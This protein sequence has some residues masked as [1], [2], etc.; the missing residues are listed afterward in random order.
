MNADC[1]PH[2]DALHHS[3]TEGTDLSPESLAHLQSC[4]A[5]RDSLAAAMKALTPEPE[6]APAP[7]V[8]PAAL[9]A[10]VQAQHDLRR[11]RRAWGVVALLG[12][13]VEGA[14]LRTEVASGAWIPAL[15]LLALVP[16]ILVAF[17]LVRQPRRY[18]FFKRLGE[19]R[20]LSGVCLGLAQRLGTPVW[21]WRVAFVLLSLWGVG[22]GLYM[23]MDLLMPVH[24][25][26]RTYL[27]RYRMARA[28]RKWRGMPVATA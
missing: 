23:L 15:L 20:Q 25:D 21:P 12:F 27:L 11:H 13:L 18:G 1:Q 3:L 7:A 19:G 28:W 26:D 24:P 17:W 16:Q 14:L 10:A 5:C 4:L 2:L 9:E 8:D 22:L 6:S